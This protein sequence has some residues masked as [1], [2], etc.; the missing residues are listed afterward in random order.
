MRIT[1]DQLAILDSFS[2]E[3][4]TA[5]EANEH[6]IQSFE[7]KRNS[8]LADYLKQNAWEEDKSNAIAFY[9]VKNVERQILF[10]FR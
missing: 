7:N 6:L 4:L 5:N 2:C 10:F 1:E 3:R 9:L 8:G